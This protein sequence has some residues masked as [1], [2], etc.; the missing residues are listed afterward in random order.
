MDYLKKATYLTAG[1]GLALS[2]GATD[3]FAIQEIMEP[4]RAKG[5]EVTNMIKMGFRIIAGVVISV[6]ILRGVMSKDQQK[7]QDMFMSAAWIA[8]GA[9]ALDQLPAVLNFIGID[10]L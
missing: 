3:C 8:G 1:I 6:Q 10:I 2:L 5:G 4:F 9:V 7:K